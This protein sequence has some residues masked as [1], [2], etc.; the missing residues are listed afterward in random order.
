MKPDLSLQGGDEPKEQI[1][2]LCDLFDHPVA[3]ASDKAALL[4]LDVALTYR[5]FGR[6]V[7]A[8]AQRLSAMVVPGEVAA[9]IPLHG[10]GDHE[11]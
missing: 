5:E 1:A 8:L 6:A 4:H 9:L 7:A 10:E 3:M 2:T 11:R